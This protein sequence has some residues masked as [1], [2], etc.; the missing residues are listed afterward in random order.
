MCRFL[1]NLTAAKEERERER[2]GPL[3]SAR[4]ASDA[5]KPRQERERERER[6]RKG[7]GEGERERER[8]REI[9]SEGGSGFLPGFPPSVAARARPRILEL[10]ST[11]M[12]GSC[13]GSAKPRL[14]S[15]YVAGMCRPKHSW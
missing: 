15:R 12:C 4:G 3:F 13:H 9:E 1:L 7:E 11:S 2:P 5:H 14:V 8:E 6:E 10:S